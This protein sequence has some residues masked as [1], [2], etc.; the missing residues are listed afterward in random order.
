MAITRVQS[1]ELAGSLSSGSTIT[2]TANVGAGNLLATM[3]TQWGGAANRAITQ[4]SDGLNGNWTQ[5]IKGGTYGTTAVSEIWYLQNSLA[6]ACTV[7]F[8]WANGA[9]LKDIFI[10]EYSGCA[11][12]GVLD[13]TDSIVVTTNQTS[14]TYATS[15]DTTSANG[16]VILGC[17]SLN[18]SAAGYS[19]TSSFT[20][21]TATE[22]AVTFAERIA[23]GSV[24]T[25]GSYT[26]T[27]GRTY[28]GVMASFKAPAGVTL[29]PQV[30]LVA[31]K[32]YPDEDW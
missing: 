24:T 13:I 3:I 19:S 28:T 6:G 17:S 25:N 10:L 23:S 9:D 29:I 16:S 12:S 8:T 14:Q 18:G 32:E 1:K 30:Q 22:S 7:T 31:P 2:F 20:Q 11:T 5:A 27:N 4:V 21:I 15:S 26:I